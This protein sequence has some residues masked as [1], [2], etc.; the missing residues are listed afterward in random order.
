MEDGQGCVST[1][2]FV[3]INY[4]KRHVFVF[5]TLNILIKQK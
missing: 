5:N 2:V 4:N 1:Q 3:L